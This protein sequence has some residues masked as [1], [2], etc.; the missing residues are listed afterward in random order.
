MRVEQDHELGREQAIRK[1]DAFLEGLRNRQPPG[2][3]SITDAR[4]SWSGNRMS[5]SFVASK[6]FFG[7]TIAGTMLVTED[8]VIVESELPGIIRALA[9]EERIKQDI[10]RE[11]ARLL[12]GNG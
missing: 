2:G 12:D 5:F 3:V 8:K 1:V 4:K 9:G 11:L 6:G 10:A 7:T